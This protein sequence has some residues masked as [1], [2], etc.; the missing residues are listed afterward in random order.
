MS[1]FKR[2]NG[3]SWEI[4]GPQISSARFDDT[5]HMIA[6]E[7]S[8]ND[9]YNVGDYVVQ[10]DKLYKCT[11]TIENAEE[12]TPAHWTQISIT[13]EVSDLNS[14]LND[15]EINSNTI[16]NSLF[17]TA[18]ASDSII[19]ID[20]G[21]ENLPISLKNLTITPKQLGSGTPSPTNKR[22]FVGGLTSLN[23]YVAP[24]NNQTDA[25]IYEI[26]FP[27]GAGTVYRGNIDFEAKTITITSVHKKLVGNGNEGISTY[28]GQ[29]MRVSAPGFISTDAYFMPI[30]SD[31]LKTVE[32]RA[33]PA[34]YAI[35]PSDQGRAELIMSITSSHTTVAAVNAWLQEHNVEIDYP[36]ATPKILKFDKIP[37][38]YMLQG[39]NYI[40]SNGDI[41]SIEYL[42]AKSSLN[43]NIIAEN[44][45]DSSSYEIG[46]YVIY[47]NN[48]F[49]CI[50][51][52]NNTEN[53]NPND[54]T[55]VI[56]TNDIHNL[57]DIINTIDDNI[58]DISDTVNVLDSKVNVINNIVADEINVTGD[59]IQIEDGIEGNLINLKTVTI[60]PTRNGS[61]TPSPTNKREFTGGYSLINL[62]VSPT[63]DLADATIKQFNLPAG[64]GV[65]YRGDIDFE[66]K[67]VIVK[68]V[69]KTL[70]GSGSE[71]I[72]IYSGWRWRISAPGLVSA[73]SSVT[74]SIYSDILNTIQRSFQ[75][76]L[77]S[78][79]QGDPN[80]NELIMSITSSHTTIDAVNEWLQENN[81][82]IDYP[83]AT[84]R[85][86]TF[87][88]IP[89]LLMLDGNNYIWSNAGEIELSYLSKKQ[90]D[91]ITIDQCTFFDEQNYTNI[92]NPNDP[93]IVINSQIQSGNSITSYSGLNISGYIPCKAGEVFKFPVYT[94]H[95]GTGSAA[96]TVCL[97]NNNKEY[98]GDI[99]GT[100]SS[101]I[102]TITIPSG[103][104]AKYFR[105]NV[106]NDDVNSTNIQSPFHSAGNFMVIK[107]N[108][109]P[110]RFYP[111]EKQPILDGIIYSGHEN[112][113]NPLYGKRVVFLGDSI[114]EGDSESG[115]AGRI[116]RENTMLWSNLGIGGSTISTALAGKCI[117]TR[118]ITMTNPDLII[119]EG[120]TN[121]ADRIGKATGETKPANWGTWS[122]SDY[123]TNDAG[124]YYGFNIDTFCGAVDYLCKRLISNY[125]GTKIGYIAAHKMGTTDATRANRGYYIAEA[126]KICRKWGIPVVDLWNEC[127]LNPMLPAL[128][129][130]NGENNFYLDGQHLTD[131]GY[132][133]IVPIITAW[134]KSL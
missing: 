46:E 133:Y 56:L 132:D 55:Q 101:S 66:A 74:M 129:T 123:G 97:F 82:E 41:L 17:E 113:N 78:I 12:W 47:N 105:V 15:V 99:T 25:T 6:P 118:P 84:P 16:M 96:K 51:N 30:Y 10:S 13:E 65:V 128:Y 50:N 22:E 49:R 98:I 40:W 115:W 67:K 94:A 73:L 52:V 59:I 119:F 83:L 24:T 91:D 111:Y 35:S 61:G 85:E 62:Y 38:I 92:Y 11:S 72:S 4:V 87:D 69:H 45:G 2:W 70:T 31:I 109:F 27:A 28:Q 8:P 90:I 103:S 108:T 112:L 116:G 23:I 32:R 33:Q 60:Q 44:F 42:K 125:P 1:V 110:D 5:N 117:C 14:A 77:Y 53:W 130:P 81:V 75:P 20:N 100:L 89:Q 126:A 29:R 71:G 131:R 88:E 48:L 64:A 79:S 127:Y 18:S 21:V 124:T 58:D 57:N 63:A 54:W 39:D 122:E 107:G 134:M 76:Q 7:Y 102:L 121:D 9:P 95:F 120:G 104:M 3:S 37:I 86:Y 114:C 26:A 93:D 43:T 34:S 106:S 68:S 19:Y 36:L 80:S